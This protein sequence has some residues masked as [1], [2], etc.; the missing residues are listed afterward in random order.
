MTPLSTSYSRDLVLHKIEG[1]IKNAK[2]N[3]NAIHEDICFTFSGYMH[4]DCIKNIILWTIL[5]HCI[6][7]LCKGIGV[8]YKQTKL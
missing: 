1:N 6:G 3:I 7:T 4:F 5:D 8:V 2:I